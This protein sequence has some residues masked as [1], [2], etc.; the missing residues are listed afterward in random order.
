MNVFD[1]CK[2]GDDADPHGDGGQLEDE[3]AAAIVRET[4]CG[5]AS[6]ALEPDAA[7]M[8]LGTEYSV[9]SVLTIDRLS[10]SLCRSCQ[11]RFYL[12]ASA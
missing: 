1:S 7:V 11:R 8:V 10:A 6:Y 4:R 2:Q 3:A 9:P 12:P 5:C